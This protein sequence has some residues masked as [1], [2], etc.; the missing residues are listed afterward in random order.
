M[1][2]IKDQAPLIASILGL[3]L[4]AVGVLVWSVPLGLIVAGIACWV[5]EWRISE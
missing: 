2:K 3:V 4:V 5:L 1:N